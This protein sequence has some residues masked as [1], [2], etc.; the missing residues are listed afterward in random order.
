M[1]KTNSFMEY[2]AP[3]IDLQ[4]EKIALLCNSTGVAT[5]ELIEDTPIIW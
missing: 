4:I 2:I 1:K 3:E 5:E